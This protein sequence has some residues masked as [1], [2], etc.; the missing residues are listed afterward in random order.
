MGKRRFNEFIK[1]LG[2]RSGVEKNEQ[3]KKALLCVSDGRRPECAQVGN[4]SNG[5]TWTA[6]VRL[7]DYQRRRVDQ[8]NIFA[9]APQPV[10]HKLGNRDTHPTGTIRTIEDENAVGHI[11]PPLI[12]PTS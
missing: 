11:R 4:A 5:S 9:S 8:L 1:T 7:R 6:V 10:D 3:L 2:P 12:R